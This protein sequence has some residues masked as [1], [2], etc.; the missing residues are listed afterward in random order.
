MGDDRIASLPGL[1]EV[2]LEPLDTLEIDEVRRLVEEE[3]VGLREERLRECNLGPLT[4]GDVFEGTIEKVKYPDTTS[5]SF[6]LILIGVSTDALVPFDKICISIVFSSFFESLL[7]FL[8][9][10]LDLSY[11]CKGISK[12]ISDGC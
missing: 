10:L 6:D 11:L 1:F 9:S 8:D 4:S 12:V 5:H 2:L 7:F 3:K